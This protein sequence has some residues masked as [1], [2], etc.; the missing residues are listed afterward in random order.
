MPRCPS[1]SNGLV[2]RGSAILKREPPFSS[3]QLAVSVSR[4]SSQ[5]CQHFA[6]FHSCCCIHQL[7]SPHT[8]SHPLVPLPQH[9]ATSANRLPPQ[10]SAPHPYHHTHTCL[11]ILPAL[12]PSH[13]T[14]NRRY[15]ALS[16][17]VSDVLL[18]ATGSGVAPLKAVLE[19][20]DLKG[21]N[22]STRL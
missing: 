22:V 8:L 16:E 18:F 10:P 12:M 5:R 11:P 21:K 19:S 17:D 7:D 20:G 15:A 4:N 2:L 13:L 1:S 3:Q 6:S 9:D 14:L